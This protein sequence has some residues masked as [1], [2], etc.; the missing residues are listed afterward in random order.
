MP[1]EKGGDRF[2]SCEGDVSVA[3]AIA[4]QVGGKLPAS[5]AAPPPKAV[6]VDPRA[7]DLYLRQRTKEGAQAG[8]EYFRQAVTQ[9]PNY[10]HAYAGIADS[11]LVLGAHGRLAQAEAFP[12]TREA[13]RW[14]CIST[15][16][17]PLSLR[18]L[19]SSIIG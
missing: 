8:L 13:A 19:I 12:K 3:R 16:P 5:D 11:Y 10:A 14:R 9:D 18:C 15:I 6:M 17:W 2:G 7:H 1:G 4:G